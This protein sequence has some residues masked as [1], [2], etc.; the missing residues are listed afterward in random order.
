MAKG[1]QESKH[2][3]RLASKPASK[4]MNKAVDKRPAL[5]PAE[6][7]RGRPAPTAVP[8]SKEVLQTPAPGRLP[9]LTPPPAAQPVQTTAPQIAMPTNLP[10]GGE[11]ITVRA[12]AEPEVIHVQKL[13]GPPNPFYGPFSGMGADGVLVRCYLSIVETKETSGGVKL[14][15]VYDKTKTKVLG[16][17]RMGGGLVHIYGEVV[18]G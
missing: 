2:D 6:L 16:W 8:K 14:A 7:P 13:D 12:T 4:P 15:R 17:G 11:P 5:A 10:R 9:V 18:E 1:K 3:A